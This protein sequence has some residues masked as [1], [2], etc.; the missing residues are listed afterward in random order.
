MPERYKIP[1]LLLI[2]LAAFWTVSIT[3]PGTTLV[4]GLVIALAAA[5]A[6]FFLPWKPVKKT[7][8]RKRY[9]KPVPPGSVEEARR[10]FGALTG[11]QCNPQT[12]ALNFD[13]TGEARAL[14]RYFPIVNMLDESQIDSFHR[15]IRSIAGH[16]NFDIQFIGAGREDITDQLP[17]SARHLAAGHLAEVF[18]FRRDILERFLHTP[19]HFQLYAAPE[20]FQQDG[21]VAGGDYNPARE[22]VQLVLSRLFEGFHEETPG[23]CPFLHE[24]GHMLDHFD[25]GSGSMG[26][27]EG[28]YP[29]LNPNDGNVFTPEA[30]ELFIKGKRLELTRYLARRTGDL[31][32]PIPIGHPYVFQNDGE[33]AAGYF[34]M[35]FRN[36]HFFAGQNRDLFDAYVALFGYDTR[37]AWERDFPHYVE[38]NRSAYASG[39]VPPEPGLSIPD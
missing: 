21:G 7:P 2:A 15:L 20:A 11:G 10:R 1:I 6:Y 25:A 28:L 33:F 39:A 8:P 27:A 9:K 29:G 26:R 3:T 32:Q 14:D 13:V 35:F 30:R 19:R 37:K 24:L 18:F 4:S 12:G 34:E 38:A 23:V 31:S 22:S 5:L 36:P 17:E 16:P